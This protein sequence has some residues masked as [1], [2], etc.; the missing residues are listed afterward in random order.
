MSGFFQDL[1]KGAAAGF[2]GNDTL[3]DYTHA[4]KTFQPDA[5][6][7]APKYKFLF[8]TYFNINTDVVNINPNQNIGLLV[9]NVKLPSYTFQ[10]VQLNQYNR[11]RI[12]QT[13][14]RYEPVTITFHDDNQN[15]INKMWQRYYNYYYADG[16][17]VVPE[18][19]NVRGGSPPP[20]GNQ[21]GQTDSPA[22]SQYNNRTIYEK[23]IAGDESWGY[24]GDTAS[25]DLKKKPFFK[26]ITVFGFNQK[27]F[28]AYTLINPVITQFGHDT[29]NYDEGNG[30]MKNTMTIDY[31]TVTYHYGKMDDRSPSDIVTGFGVES[32]DGV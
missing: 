21:L 30:T 19:A 27:N 12:I 23:S 28:T 25:P 2:F 22:L 18:F 17:R 4:A 20:A 7:F 29:Y 9:N 14:I 8:H 16:A 15:N 10:T 3:R 13:K 32:N 6:A 31:E 26:D 11:K 24:V 1:L 5:Y